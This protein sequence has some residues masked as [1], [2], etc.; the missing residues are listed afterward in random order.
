MENKKRIDFLDNLRTFIIFLVLVLHAGLPFTTPPFAGWVHDEQAKSSI[1]GFWVIFLEG[2]FLMSTMFFIAGYFILPSLAKKGTSKFLKDKFIRLGI[3]F[4]FGAIIISP[5][6]ASISTLSDGYN[7]NFF[8]VCLGFFNPMYY[9]HYHFWFLGI[10]IYF[11][12][13]TVLVLNIFKK[14]ISLLPTKSTKPKAI[15]FV[16]F[17]LGCIVAN[18]SIGVLTGNFYDWFRS[19][20]LVFQKTSLPLYMA[21][22]TLGIYA[23]KRNWFKD[24][25]KP[26]VLPWTIIYVISILAYCYIYFILLMFNPATV[27][28]KLIVS[29]VYNIAMF[30]L[31][32][33]LLGIFQR[34]FNG[35]GAF[36]KGLN[37]SSF[38]T[39]VFHMFPMFLVFYFVRYLPVAFELRLFLDVVLGVLLSWLLG[40]IMK[41]VP[42]LR[43]IL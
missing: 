39:Y 9:A 18:F 28:Q 5:I 25:Y 3:P 30:S 34:F 13:I 27:L 24:G 26:K 32:Q 7:Y 21:Y 22:Y 31:I 38:S 40:F 36:V 14:K 1:M 15:L 4:L 41:K 29:I 23:Y 35:G 37:Q 43:K 16:L 20:H 17:I 33:M 10:L 2:P 6:L 12:L 8:L 11:I 19:Y 42:L